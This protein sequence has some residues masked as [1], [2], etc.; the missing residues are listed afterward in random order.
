MLLRASLPDAVGLTSPDDPTGIT[1]SRQRASLQLLRYPR[2]KTRDPLQ[3]FLFSPFLSPH[4][5]PSLFFS[6]SFE[7][8]FFPLRNEDPHYWNVNNGVRP[9]RAL[10]PKGPKGQLAGDSNSQ[11]CYFSWSSE[12]TFWQNRMN[13]IEWLK[14]LSM[15]LYE[16]SRNRGLFVLNVQY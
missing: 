3:I 6:L 14:T 12:H 4:F 9:Q 5:S 11:N 1:S 7:G 16:Y 10:V 15:T 13:N 2:P 8:R